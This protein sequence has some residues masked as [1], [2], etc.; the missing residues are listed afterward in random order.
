[1]TH[2][3]PVHHDCQPQGHQQP[4]AMATTH[5]VLKHSISFHCLEWMLKQLYMQKCNGCIHHSF[6]IICTARYHKY[7]TNLKY[8]SQ[9]PSSF[10]AA[11]IISAYRGARTSSRRQR[12]HWDRLW[13]CPVMS[14]PYQMSLRL[15][16]NSK[17]ALT[18]A[19]RPVVTGRGRQQNA[20]PLYRSW[21]KQYSQN[22]NVTGCRREKT[23]EECHR[24]RKLLQYTSCISDSK[25]TILV[26]ADIQGEN[27]VNSVYPLMA[28]NIREKWQIW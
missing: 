7:V 20:C 15:E 24:D 22:L 13:P 25:A 26:I 6:D 8:P 12:F 1:M 16:D 4:M 11:S 18:W 17:Y 19:L 5:W 23:E 14:S 2:L 28:S 10:A 27:R 9:E 21:C 3:I